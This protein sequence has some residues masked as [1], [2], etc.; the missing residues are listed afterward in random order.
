MGWVFAG[1]G[2][3]AGIWIGLRVAG[4]L[5]PWRW[6]NAAMICAGVVTGFITFCIVMETHD[7]LFGTEQSYVGLDESDTG[8]PAE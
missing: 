6:P 1:L 4:S 3:I 5:K 8:S 2:V 7:L